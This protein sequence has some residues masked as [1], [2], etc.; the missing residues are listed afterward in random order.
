LENK[1]SAKSLQALNRAAVAFRAKKSSEAEQL[2][3]SIL[4][5]DPNC[6]E[7][8]Y[9]L[10]VIHS[11][12]GKNEQALASYDKAL[13][14]RPGF[15]EA[16]Y[17][18]G[19][20][21][22]KLHRLDEALASYDR[23]IA[24]Q[25][26]YAKAFSNRGN[27]L[28]ELKRF[29]E[30]LT[31]YD[32][33]LALQPNLVEALYNRGNTL[34][35]LKRF[36]EALASYDRAVVAQPTY[37]KAIY[38]RANT[39][40][41]MQRFDE[42][43]VGY[44]RAIRLNP[45]YAEALYNRGNTL[46]ELKR[47]SDALDSYDRAISVRG[48]DANSLS[49][50]GVT[51]H[52]LKRFE[53]AVADFD[54]SLA[55]R[56]N[57]PDIL[58]NRGNSLAELKRFNDAIESYDRAL[59][60]DMTHAQALSG[61]AFNVNIICNW[62]RRLSMGAAIKEHVIGRKAAISPFVVLG[63]SDDPALQLQC[64]KNYINQK[65]QSN[66]KPLWSG[67][68][69]RHQKLR[70][71]YLSAD[72]HSHPTAS[73]MAELFELHDRSKFEV[74]GISFGTDDHSAMRK[75]LVSA[76]DVF[77]DVRDRSAG[78]IANY[79]RK[80]E[81]DIAV[82]LKGYTS[83]ARPEILAQRPTPIQVNYLGYPGTMGAP[84]IDYI[85]ADPVIAPFEKEQFYAEKIVQLPD[86]YQPND[87]K[88]E[89]N[90]YRP[91]RQSVGLPDNKFVFCCFNNNWKIGPESFDVWMRL[92]KKVENSVLWLLADNEMAEQNLRKEAQ[93]RAVDASRLVFA[94]RV[95]IE[96]HLAR[97]RCADLFLDTIPCNA[98]TTA[99]DALWTGLPL[100]TCTGDAFAGRVA[101]SLL[102][103]IGLPELITKNLDEYE[104]RA[105]QIARDVVLLAEL[106]AKIARNRSTHAL[107][108]SQQFAGHL[109]AAYGLMWEAWQR[110]ERPKNFRVER[111][112]GKS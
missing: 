14:L 95:P 53:D 81:I 50:R 87:S 12:L 96:E 11:S 102:Q 67:E 33:A 32:Q 34:H 56:P 30:A 6:F 78:D 91:S 24:L 37:A 10:G 52:E 7:A 72:F 49:N 83:G 93:R 58:C 79:L 41:K 110:G 42:A 45:T 57:D 99:S 68:I 86:C 16:M 38:N 18:R 105:L 82:D 26:G 75:R 84:F 40:A 104:M 62:D 106:K 89:I 92:L 112:V 47:L 55:L 28:T 88:R 51:L 29:E 109:E 94:P 21:L 19:N 8:I 46:R 54:R 59:A 63:Y 20:V 5:E 48:D 101:S 9:F 65:I 1:A 107:F 25:P 60:V 64:A 100:L 77:Q 31:S 61:L 35:E 111:I 36:E 2:C 4:S 103:A 17:N 70:V 27:T 85:I 39:L 15:A 74:L 23:T 97:H 69:W 98:H 71:A 44:D 90:G 108:N 73:L 76:F 43:L 22:K 13:A 80:S 3:I 66:P